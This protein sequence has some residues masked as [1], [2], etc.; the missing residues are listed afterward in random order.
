MARNYGENRK[1][2]E[3]IIDISEERIAVR[4][5][6]AV[7]KAVIYKYRPQPTKDVLGRACPTTKIKMTACCIIPK[8]K[9]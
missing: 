9:C 3:V 4:D 6:G 7:E 8:K 2:N 1:G 5:S